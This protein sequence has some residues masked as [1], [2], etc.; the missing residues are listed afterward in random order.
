MIDV[1]PIANLVLVFFFL[2]IKFMFLY[3]K[4]LFYSSMVIFI[5]LFIEV[6]FNWHNLKYLMK[7][8]IQIAKACIIRYSIN[9]K[10]V[11]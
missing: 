5:Y 9:I 11:E 6:V 4:L 2:Q 3:V 10:D 1:Y 7:I 8:D